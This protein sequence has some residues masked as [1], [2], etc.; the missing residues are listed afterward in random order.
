[1]KINKLIVLVAAVCAVMA[2]EKGPEDSGK[3]SYSEM[4]FQATAPAVQGLSLAWTRG[5][6]ISIFDGK[7]N[8]KFIT[9]AG[10]ASAEFTGTANASAS[11]FMA[12]SPYD[13]NLSRKSGK[14]SMTIPAAQTGVAGGIDAN[15][16]IMAAYAKS[17]K[18]ALAFK[19]MPAFLKLEIVPGILQLTG[20]QITAKGGENI[21]GTV[22][23]G[24]FETPTIEIEATKPSASV[25][26][27]GTDLSGVYYV[28]V[29][30]QTVADGFTVAFTDKDDKRAEVEVTGSATL[31]S[32]Q[33]FD[34]G[35]FS[36][37]DFAE[38]TNPNPTQVEKAVILKAS[39]EEADFNM[40]SDGGFEYYPDEVRGAHSSWRAGHDNVARVD[41][42]TGKAWMFDNATAGWW[43]DVAIQTI[44][45]RQGMTFQYSAYLK[46]N[47]PHIYT[48][49]QAYG[50]VS[51]RFE[52]GGADVNRWLESNSPTT[53]TLVEKE[54][55]IPQGAFYGS[56]FCGIWG[57]AA[58]A[59]PLID[60]G[61]NANVHLDDVCVVPKNYNKKSM[62]TKT[63]TLVGAVR[64]ETF[65]EVTDLGTV[66]A[67]KAADGKINLAFSNVTIN[68]TEYDNAVALTE[69]TDAANGLMISKF[70]K[71]SG[72][73][74]PVMEP[75]T[76]ELS[77]V[78]NNVFV[79]GDK[80]YMHY[81]A[82]LLETSPNSWL[83]SRAGF[84]VSEDGG[85]T[86]TPTQATWLGTFEDIETNFKGKFSS[87]SYVHK[88]NYWYVVGCAAGRTT[89]YFDNFFAARVAD[90]MDVSNP[91]NYE[92][93]DGLAWVT[94]EES[95]IPK[96]ACLT[97]GDRSEPAVIYNP[98]FGRYMLIFRS[99]MHAGLVY[100]DADCIE[101]PWSGEK[102]LTKDSVDGVLAAPS[103]LGVDETT[104]DVVILASKVQ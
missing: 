100:R 5:E 59:P 55:E 7:A 8:Q 45:L 26:L 29:Y 2:C 27:T 14:V 69:N 53:W 103:V 75:A 50:A 32:G 11:V 82:T 86:W 41:G 10:G 89:S 28:A 22:Q 21:A 91:A 79:A 87:A 12:V 68:G 19:A 61:N 58:G 49:I 64:N 52:R 23:V 81:C 34:L 4:T 18:D 17:S 60:V 78:P 80:T 40:V 72:I 13:A 51:P 36:R 63:V 54:A 102:I 62:D 20:A 101:G 39:F 95:A 1:M 3:T 16:V 76:G 30:P 6:A 66:T 37:F 15:N 48:G 92:Y 83:T 38:S 98:K 31:V 57:D 42:R 24:L 84:V 33:V 65:D 43:C 71:N 96:S 73:I 93:W 88:D 77:I 90:N 104:G 56:I 44:A 35:S 70:V 94:I 9:A 46:G 67:W 99:N 97:V 74:T 85:L 25:T 47:T